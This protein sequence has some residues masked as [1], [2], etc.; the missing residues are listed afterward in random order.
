[1]IN[2]GGC[3]RAE[4]RNRLCA[5]KAAEYLSQSAIAEC[6]AEFRPPLNRL[7]EQQV[8][9]EQLNRGLPVPAPHSPREGMIVPSQRETV[10]R[11]LD[12]SLLV[13][14]P[15][16]VGDEQIE[17]LLPFLVSLQAVDGKTFAAIML[18]VATA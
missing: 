17:K 12:P 13:D 4:I 2:S 8:I 16:V 15:C 14:D 1:M 6:V 9:A 7:E 18:E 10:H 3:G 11:L 5:G